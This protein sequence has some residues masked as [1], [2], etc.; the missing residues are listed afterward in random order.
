[1]SNKISLA[2][3]AYVD[4]KHESQ[5]NFSLGFP[6]AVNE[7]AQHHNLN[8]AAKLIMLVGCDDMSRQKSL[9]TNFPA[10]DI[11]EIFEHDAV[12]DRIG[13]IVPCAGVWLD[14][15][16]YTGAQIFNRPV[17]IDESKARDYMIAHMM[18]FGVPRTVVLPQAC[19]V[20]AKVIEG[21]GS[22]TF[23]LDFDAVAQYV[24]GYPCFLKRA[25]GGGRRDVFR[26]K[27]KAELFEQY[28]A[29]R[30]TLMVLQQA[31]EFDK[32]VRTFCFGRKVVHT[33][34]DI[35]K[36]DGQK[37]NWPNYL[38]DEERHYLDQII[39]A[40]AGELLTPFCTT[41]I[42]H[43]VKD[44]KWYFIDITNGCNFDM[45]EGELTTPI[46]SVAKQ[47]LI[48][49][50]VE[51]TLNPRPMIVHAHLQEHVLC[52]QLC[53][54]HLKGQNLEHLLRYAEKIGF[55]VNSKKCQQELERF[56]A[57]YCKLYG[58]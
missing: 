25:N 14:N 39:P 38:S 49:E 55:A 13:T 44:G 21:S 31:V 10:F 29:T 57:E 30:E 52:Q 48:E 43:S 5:V 23:D 28:Q 8:L 9:H 6:D 16:L 58:Q 19:Y 11:G 26:V 17:S 41:E 47:N 34:Y 37:Y 40:L 7:F 3:C 46:F 12:F 22:I 4:G 33:V 56:R 27:N 18:G 51:W 45:R 42:A 1:M 50:L 54:G 24:G 2:M 36:P 20:R 35:D 15:G 53:R 32:Y